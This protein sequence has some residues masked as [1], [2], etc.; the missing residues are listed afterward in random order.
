MKAIFILF[1]LCSQTIF[2][3]DT[4]FSLF[5]TYRFSSQVDKLSASVVEPVYALSQAGRDRVLDL[6]SQGYSCKLL[7]RQ[8][9]RCKKFDA[10][11]EPR[12]SSRERLFA[13]FSRENLEFVGSQGPA[14]IISEGD[15][16]T[17]FRVEGRV[18]FLGESFESYD[19]GISKYSDHQIHKLLLK[20][21]GRATQEFIV[22]S[23]ERL[24]R[25][26]SFS[27]QGPRKFYQFIYEGFFELF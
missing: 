25:V 9:Y 22:H 2:A 1:L 12:T 27:N 23:S 8:T 4:P 14:Y 17:L 20:K 26:K 21:Q 11:F 24:G 16:Y 13:E 19:Y 10:T 7:P 5:G 15:A 3:A 18:S 6:K